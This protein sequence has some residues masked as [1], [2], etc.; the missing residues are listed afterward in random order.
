MRLLCTPAAG[1]QHR[2]FAATTRACCMAWR[3]IFARAAVAIISLKGIAKAFYCLAQAAARLRCKVL[4][5]PGDP[6]L[7]PCAGSG[8]L[9]FRDP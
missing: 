6:A 5:F 1:M 7:S 3:E 2:E 9:A 4:S 8:E